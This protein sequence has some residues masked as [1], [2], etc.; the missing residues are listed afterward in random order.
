MARKGQDDNGGGVDQAIVLGYI[1]VKEE[2]TVE[3]QVAILT[4]LGY[5]NKQIATICGK[6][7]NAIRALKSKIGVTK[8]K[9][10]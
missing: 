1:A 3:K 2:E 5:G 10:R 8:K 9:G 4:Q 7:E 6:K